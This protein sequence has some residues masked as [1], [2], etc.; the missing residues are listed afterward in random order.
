MKKQY[1]QGDVLIEEIITEITTKKSKETL[2]VR[3]EGRNHGHFI[4]G[5]EVYEG[6]DNAEWFVDVKS[7]AFLEH[8]LIDTGISAKEHNTIT[9]PKGRYRV[10][11]QVEYNPYEKAIQKVQD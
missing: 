10:I 11:R 8:L 5:A 1:R 7:E 6:D 9:V 3:G 2:L 4:R